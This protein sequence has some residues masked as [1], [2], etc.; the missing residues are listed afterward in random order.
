MQVPVRQTSVEC[1]PVARSALDMLPLELWFRIFYSPELDKSDWVKCASSCKAVS[2]FMRPLL[3]EEFAVSTHVVSINNPYSWQSKEYLNRLERRVEFLSTSGLA[4]LVR[5]FKIMHVRRDQTPPENYRFSVPSES[6]IYTSLLT[7]IP[8]LVNLH[9]VDIN[10]MRVPSVLLPPLVRLSS[11][12]FITI[13]SRLNDPV[14]PLPELACNLTSLRLAHFHR[15]D[16]ISSSLVPSLLA[17]SLEDLTL[18]SIH[19]F[20]LHHIVLPTQ[21]TPMRSLRRL[22][23]DRSVLCDKDLPQALQSF[24]AAQVLVLYAQNPSAE[25]PPNLYRTGLSPDVLPRLSHLVAQQRD[26]TVFKASPI[27][28]ITV[29]FSGGDSE[30]TLFQVLHSHFPDVASLELEVNQPPLPT[31]SPFLTSFSHLRY[32]RIFGSW[33]SDD[34]E[35]CP[36]EQ[37]SRP[38]RVYTVL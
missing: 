24:S 16:P 18:I 20:D 21:V 38:Y 10:A 15:S 25:P 19:P 37:V 35:V 2:S 3:F 4:E 12:I 6:D 8:K 36:D 13:H 7:L 28:H 1:A 34:P 29:P 9:S 14:D 32:L 26:L 5:S 22:A 17:P 33:F 23:L 30:E 27:R 11:L 31:I